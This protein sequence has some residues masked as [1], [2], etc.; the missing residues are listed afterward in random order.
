MK[1][2][3]ASV[4]ELLESAERAFETGDDHAAV[5]FCNR[6]LTLKPAFPAALSLLARA[7]ARRRDNR[8]R[9]VLQQ[10]EKL[11]GARGVDLREGDARPRSRHR[12]VVAAHPARSR[13]SS[14]PR[15][16]RAP[17]NSNAPSASGSSR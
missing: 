13:R 9:E 12:S 10:A 1:P 7:E 6:I 8:L 15:S 4:S 14:K 5:E 16:R 3:Q 11:M 2:S 17:R